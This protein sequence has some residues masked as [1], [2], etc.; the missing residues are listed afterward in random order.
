MILG[1]LMT[2]SL[3]LLKLRDG[4]TAWNRWRKQHPEIRP[5]LRRA[6]LSKAKLKDADL[7]D[8]DLREADLSYADLRDVDL[9]DADLRKTNLRN[10]D[11]REAYLYDAD[12][13][14]AS[15]SKA[16]LRGADLQW[17]ELTKANL[18]SCNLNN[19]SLEGAGLFKASLL[20]ANLVGANLLEADLSMAELVG[21]NLAGASLEDANLWGANL[22]RAN[23]VGADLSGS[24]LVETNFSYANLTDCN[25]FGSS[26]WNVDLKET[27]QP[28]LTITQQGESPIQVDSLEVAQFIYLLL[29]NK[30]IRTVIETI[31]SKVV[32]I[33]GR[34]TP[35][36]KVVL[37]AIR[38][39]L[40]KRDYLPV[41]FDFEKPASKDLTGTILTLANMARF[42]VA[43]LT[44]PSSVPYELGRFVPT[45]KVPVRTIILAGHRVPDMYWD[46]ERTY[47]WVLP[48]HRY[49]SRRLLIAQLSEQVLT[50]AEEK[51]KELRRK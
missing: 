38:N 48:L 47:H 19:A 5:N 24:T 12:L 3:N 15:L 36:R 40:R 26:V 37:D 14:N 9:S 39:E 46:L 34:F 21:A 51:V 42:V 29:N 16:D 35:Q 44:D 32:L 20:G 13:E 33:L 11:L 43:D 49:K 17:A 23:L 30:K 7:S 25:V 27:I 50:P 1:V 10:A 6:T 4:V 28:N 22:S 2:N 31:N 8:T 45:T 18:N 41:L